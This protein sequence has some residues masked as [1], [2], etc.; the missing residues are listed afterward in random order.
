VVADI[1]ALQEISERAPRADIAP[2][3]PLAAISE[4]LGTQPLGES[5]VEG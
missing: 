5:V 3:F 1:E 4:V 2:D